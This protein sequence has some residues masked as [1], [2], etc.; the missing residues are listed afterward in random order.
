MNNNMLRMNNEKKDRYRP[1]FCTFDFYSQN[2]MAFK[3]WKTRFQSLSNVEKVQA[4]VLSLSFLRRPKDWYGGVRKRSFTDETGINATHPLNLIDLIEE[5]PIYCPTQLQQGVSLAT[6]L[7][8]CKVKPLPESCL[9]S[10]F[11]L[12]DPN[13]PLII[14]EY[15]PTPREL[16]DYQLKG[17]RVVT[18]NENCEAWPSMNCG[19]RDFLSFIIHDLIHA[20]HFLKDNKNKNS[21]LGFYH[22]VQGIWNEPS[23]HK[24]LLS[25]EFKTGFEYIISD[26]NSHPVHLFKTLQALLQHADQHVDPDRSEVKNIWNSWISIWTT[27]HSC[28]DALQKINTQ[29]FSDI[30]ALVLENL[31]F[32]NGQKK[33][34]ENRINL[35]QY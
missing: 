16:L 4:W 17:M 8:S 6:L 22:F 34:L 11:S 18:F 29:L 33:H 23:L 14:L 7:N 24:L 10:L 27:Q 32:E 12:S 5:L 35:V 19:G 21:Q 26:M 13:F 1:L 25:T 20:D 15:I 31:C 30:D 3:L 2:Q 28:I 9:R